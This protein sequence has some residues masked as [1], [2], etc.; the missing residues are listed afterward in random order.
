MDG[1]SESL[2]VLLWM[3]LGLTLLSSEAFT[4]SFHLLFFG[5]AALVVASMGGLGLDVLWIQIL[6]FS[7]LCGVSS[8]MVAWR[9]RRRS[10]DEFLLGSEALVKIWDDFAPGEEKEIQYQ[11]APWRARNHSEKFLKSGEIVEVSGTHGLTL[12]LRSRPS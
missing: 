12:L 1:V 2:H 5:L 7:A 6:I 9:M 11:G 4:G 10:T 3:I 8:L